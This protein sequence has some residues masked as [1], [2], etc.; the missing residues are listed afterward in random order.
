MFED[1]NK[2]KPGDFSLTLSIVKINRLI[3]SILK[4][5]RINFAGNMNNY[6]FFGN[7]K[8][9]FGQKDLEHLYCFFV[10]IYRININNYRFYNRLLLKGKDLMVLKCFSLV[11]R[12][13]KLNEIKWNKIK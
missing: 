2:W 7:I 1:I 4:K 13:K 6:I 8:V 10:P 11:Q 12:I 9:F 3:S 5:N